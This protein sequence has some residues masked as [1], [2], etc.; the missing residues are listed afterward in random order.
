MV[1]DAVEKKIKAIRD[2]NPEVELKLIDS[3]VIYTHGNYEK[4][5]ETL[6]EGAVLAVIVVL[7]FLRDIRATLIAA[8]TLPLSILPA[9]WTMELMGFTLN[10]VTFVAITLSTGIIVDDAIV[11]IENIE[12]HIHMGKSPYQAAM[13]AA[14]EIGLAVIAISLAII[15]VF[16]PASFMPGVIGQFFKQFGITVSVQVFFSL[17]AA[18][19]ITP[20]LAAYFLKPKPHT[21]KPLG[22]VMRSY[23]GVVK[24]SVRHSLLTV[25]IGLLLFAGAVFIGQ[26]LKSTLMPAQDTARSQLAIEL[27]AGSQL[28]ETESVTE[29]IVKRLRGRAEIKSIFV[30]GGSIPRGP[31]EVRNA[32]LT[33]NYV[34]KGDRKSTQ[35]ELERAISKDLESIPDIR[36]WFLDENGG[37]GVSYTVTGKDIMTVKNVAAELANQMKRIPFLV[38]VISSAALD[39]PELQIRP[40]NDLA[41]RLGVVTETLSESIRVATIGDFGPALA[42]FDAGD[43]LIPIRVQLEDSA[44]TDPQ[45][46]E[47]L[48]VPMGGGGGVPLRSVADIKFD[49]GPNSIS[50]LDRERQATVAADLTGDAVIGDALK[51]IDKLPIMKG[52]PSG[53]TVTAGGDAEQMKETL[54][55]FIDVAV[56]ALMMVYA[57][58]VLLFGSFLQPITILFSLPLSAGGAFVALLL[59]G[60]PTSIPVYIGLLMLMGIVTKNAIMLVDFAIEMIAHGADR[61]Q[62]IVEAGVKRARPIVMTTIAMAAG[63]LPSALA[64]GA[65]GE[66]RSPMA[67]AVIGGLVVSTLLSLVFVPA[68]FVVMDDLGR[69]IW[70]AFAKLMLSSEGPGTSV[71]AAATNQT[72]PVKAN[73]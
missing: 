28:A 73:E 7:L 16:V 29:E 72:V 58:L 61:K 59:T 48:R 23:A 2:A 45:V 20:V 42:R 36:Y 39:R 4:A 33:I 54:S 10:L 49:Q 14:D 21:E 37:R 12:R 31:A 38:N 65:G 32:S 56:K 44:R 25:L 68:F 35:R 41:T 3:S 9:F 53:V 51:T 1:A 47:Q 13:E 52:L 60:S 69:L 30:I 71:S 62:A 70:R 26:S 17:L 11:E 22:V 50:R 64:I 43:R 24:W 67:I 8:V 34:T 63:M 5:I 19:F 18:R 40:R 27:P 55:D 57:L 6:F 66:F 15:A 46:L